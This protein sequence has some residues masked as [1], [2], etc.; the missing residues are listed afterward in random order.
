VLNLFL[1]LLVIIEVLLIII[2][3]FVIKNKNLTKRENLVIDFMKLCSM[4]CLLTYF[5]N[6][7]ELYFSIFAFVFEAINLVMKVFCNLEDKEQGENKKEEDLIT[8]VIHSNSD[9]GDKD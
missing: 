1:I 2:D 3:V 7:S 4:I 8:D 6:V 9:E 5:F